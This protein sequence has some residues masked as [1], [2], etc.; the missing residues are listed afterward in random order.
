MAKYVASCGVCQRVKAEH[1]SFAGKLQFLEVRLQLKSY[2]TMLHGTVQC[3][4][5][6]DEINIYDMMLR[7]VDGVLHSPCSAGW[8]WRLELE[9]SERK[10]LLPGWWLEAGTGVV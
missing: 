5:I 4:L 6:D 10:I 1:K 2:A 9:W 8:S 3:P 7:Q